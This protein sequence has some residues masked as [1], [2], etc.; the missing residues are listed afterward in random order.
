[1]RK[2]F[3]LLALAAACIVAAPANALL[4][5]NGWYW[6]P[7]ESGRGFNIEVQNN[8]LFMAAFV[9]DSQGNAIWLV[10]G[11]PMSSDHTYVGDVYQTSG[12]QCLGCAYL[13]DPTETKYGTASITFTSGTTAVISINGAA[14]SVQREEFG[15]DFSNP[16]TPLLGEWATTEGGPT[17]PVYFGDRITLDSAQALSSG[18]TAVGNRS[19]DLSRSAVAAYIPASGQ[20]AI[21]L[22]SSTSFY[23]IYT[24]NFVGFNTIDGFESTY[25]KGTSPVGYLDFVAQRTKSGALVS[26]INAPGLSKSAPAGVAAIAGETDVA[27][28]ASESAEKQANPALREAAALL[29]PMLRH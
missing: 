27:R 3:L 7:A 2:V 29:E 21:L 28:V 26:G 1:M 5:D 4:P 20:W 11:G 12:G 18:L 19:G 13:G 6:N 15:F 10:T 9:Y 17:I 14:V 24:F 23:T 8:L 22:D 25:L 16:A